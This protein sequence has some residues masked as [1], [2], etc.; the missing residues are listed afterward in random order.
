MIAGAADMSATYSAA[1][2]KQSA[3]PEDV[4]AC[5]TARGASVGCNFE[6]LSWVTGPGCGP[7]QASLASTAKSAAR[8]QNNKPKTASRLPLILSACVTLQV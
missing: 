4:R 8:T 7:Y 2:R 3:A 6:E 1:V 5:A